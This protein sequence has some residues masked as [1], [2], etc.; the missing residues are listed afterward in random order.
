M[1]I[2]DEY[3]I[4]VVGGFF[5]FVF[6]AIFIYLYNLKVEIVVSECSSILDCIFFGTMLSLIP[7]TVFLFYYMNKKF[8]NK[9]TKTEIENSNNKSIATDEPEEEPEEFIVTCVYCKKEHIN[10]TNPLCSK[11]GK[12]MY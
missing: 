2:K 11:C 12:N 4:Y 10:P 7:T 6:S 1:K 3:I 9:K 8:D 5:A